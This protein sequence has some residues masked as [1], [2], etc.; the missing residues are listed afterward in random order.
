M[1]PI[2]AIEDAFPIYI[3]GLQFGYRGCRSVVN[4]LR[5]PHCGAI[6]EVVGSEALAL[7]KNFRS[8]DTP[9]SHIVDAGL[10]DVVV[11]N[12]GHIDRFEAEIG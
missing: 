7:T 3:A 8:V 10:T 5:C 9:L 1:E 6:L 11:R 2:F 12:G 4:H